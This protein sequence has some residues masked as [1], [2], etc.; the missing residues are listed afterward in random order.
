[1]PINDDLSRGPSLASSTRPRESNARPARDPRCHHIFCGFARIDAR[2]VDAFVSIEAF[3]LEAFSLTIARRKRLFH[4]SNRPHAHAHRNRIFLGTRRRKIV[5][6]T[7]G[8][9]A[10]FA[11]IAANR[12]I[13]RERFANGL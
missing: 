5:A 8:K 12:R 10:R 2:E 1:M 7:R 4:D 9:R 13:A 11:R 6:M 3:A